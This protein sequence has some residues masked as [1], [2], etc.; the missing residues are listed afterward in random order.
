METTGPILILTA[1]GAN[2]QV[3]INAVAARFPAV[4]VVVEQ[5][6]GKA[7][8]WRRRTRKLGAIA[9][10]GQLATMVASRLLKSLAARRSADILASYGVSAAESPALPVHHVASLNEPACH[11]LLQRLNPSV[12]VTVSCRLLG[13]ATLATIPCPIINLHAGINPAYRGQMGGYW[14]LVENDA[15]NFG[16]TVHLVDAGTDT[17]GTLY[18]VRAVRSPR[19]FI[20]TYPL[21]LTAAATGIVI[22]AIEDALAGTLSPRT[23]PGPSALRFPPTIWTWLW[24]GLIRR[25][26]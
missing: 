7:E 10:T 15:A 4:E 16:A 12:V 3:V 5:P 11:Q 14:S 8:I 23:M 18:E 2:P 19:D 22:R 17:G 6:E 9:A 1:G 21:L 26:W 20:S 24:N 13:R 25:I